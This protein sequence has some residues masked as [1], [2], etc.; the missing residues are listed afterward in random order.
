MGHEFV[1]CLA[2]LVC[3][4][5]EETLFVK[6]TSFITFSCSFFN[7]IKFPDCALVYSHYVFS[8]N[9]GEIP[10]HFHS[11]RTFIVIFSLFPSGM[12]HGMHYIAFLFYFAWVFDTGSRSASSNKTPVNI[13][14][15]PRRRLLVQ[16]VYHSKESIHDYDE[17]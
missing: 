8:V 16:R 12:R 6:I 11:M 17:F 4:H 3:M 15:F 10:R 14:V 2:F 9:I 13:S 1:D 5:F 7:Q